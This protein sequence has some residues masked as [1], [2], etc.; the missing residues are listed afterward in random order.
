MTAVTLGCYATA[1]IGYLITHHFDE[2]PPSYWGI[3]AGVFVFYFGKEA[4]RNIR[5][6]QNGNGGA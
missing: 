6:T 5:V 1:Q 4:F 3:N 2:L